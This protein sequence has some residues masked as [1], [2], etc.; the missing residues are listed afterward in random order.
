MRRHRHEAHAGQQFLGWSGWSGPTA[1]GEIG[2]TKSGRTSKTGSTTR[3]SAKWSNRASRTRRSPKLAAVTFA[4]FSGRRGANKVDTAGQ[5]S[6][7][8]KTSGLALDLGALVSV[9]QASDE[10]L[11]WSHS[12]RSHS[13]SSFCIS[14]R[15][16]AHRTRAVLPLSSRSSRWPNPVP[17]SVLKIISATL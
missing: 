16:V 13:F 1:R 11:F 3:S 15:R 9:N 7:V 5:T 2:P 14:S 17:L 12:G 6:T 4:A 10:R 8:P